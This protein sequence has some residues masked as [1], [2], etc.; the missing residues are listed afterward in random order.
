[1]HDLEIEETLNTLTLLIDTREQLTEKLS[2]RI[3]TAQL[4]YERVKL[5]YG[6]YSAKCDLLDL[7]QSVVIERK[8]NLDELALCLGSQRKRFEA[9]FKRAKENGA[10]VY[11]LIENANWDVLFNEESYKLRCHSKYTAK[12]MIASL[13][14]FM[15]R[16]GLKVVFC[17]E[18]NTGYLIREILF[19][20]M[21]ERLRNG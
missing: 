11:L 17:N 4:P 21:K 20:E 6:D 5:N 7:S 15:S 2:E 13:T 16:Y 9:E 1:M 18:K 8:M 19:R 10:T 12:A 14:A 3:K